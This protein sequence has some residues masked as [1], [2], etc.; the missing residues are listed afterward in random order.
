MADET[1]MKGKLPNGRPPFMKAAAGRK[2]DDA[3]RKAKSQAASRRLQ[4]LKMKS[5]GK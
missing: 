4:L 3:A 1:D 2:T 5:K